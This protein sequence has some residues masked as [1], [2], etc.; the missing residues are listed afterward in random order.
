MTYQQWLV[1]NK[2]LFTPYEEQFD[3]QKEYLERLGD[4]IKKFNKKIN[5]PNVFFRS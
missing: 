5:R 2:H 3:E 4:D 1:W